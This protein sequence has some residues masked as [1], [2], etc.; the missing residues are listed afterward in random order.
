MQGQHKKINLFTPPPAYLSVYQQPTGSRFGGDALY[1]AQNR[2]YGAMISYLL[3]KNEDV[4][5]EKNDEVKEENIIKWDSLYFKIYW[6]FT[7]PQ[8]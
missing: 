2:K 4:Q 5:D 8:K 3:N 6:Y 7:L 1:N